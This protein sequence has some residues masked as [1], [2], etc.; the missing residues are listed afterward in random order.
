V[1]A[2]GVGV[3]VVVLV[4]GVKLSVAEG[5]GVKLAVQ[6]ISVLTVGVTVPCVS[7]ATERKK[8]PTQ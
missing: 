2:V 3:G 6:V 1:V 7:G 5:S 8:K 4:K